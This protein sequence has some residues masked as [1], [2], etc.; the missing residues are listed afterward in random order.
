MP[1]ILG[2]SLVYT[3]TTTIYLFLNDTNSTDDDYYNDDYNDKLNYSDR[4]LVFVLIAVP[5]L[6]LLCCCICDCCNDTC[7]FNYSSSPRTHNE[8]SI[9]CCSRCC[10]CCSCSCCCCSKDKLTNKVIYPRSKS[11]TKE[12]INLKIRYSLCNEKCCIC[13]EPIKF[14]SY[15]IKSCGHR[16]FHKSC[17]NKWIQK[18]N[19]CPMCRTPII[20]YIN[21]NYQSSDNEN[22]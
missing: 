11:R 3:Q 5:L 16:N 4:L 13:H 18:S 7:Y 8:N 14:K 12:L 2:T 22:D 20:D 15:Q 10:C 9:C 21:E 17:L 19:E 1:S 6:F